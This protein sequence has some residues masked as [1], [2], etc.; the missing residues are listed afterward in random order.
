MTR[1]ANYLTFC[2]IVAVLLVSSAYGS[3]DLS[4]SG[5]AWL[6]TE[7]GHEGYWKYCYEVTWSNL[8]HGVSHL[9]FLLTMLEDCPCLCT[10]GYFVFEDTVGTGPGVYGE[11]PCTVLYYGYFE[12]EGDPSIPIYGPLIKFEPYEGGC[13]PS[14][15]GTAYLCYY[16]VAAP[17]Y[18][19]WVDYL[20]IKF[21][22][23]SEYGT[24]TGPLPSC[25]TGVSAIEVSTWGNVKALYR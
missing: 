12:C 8:P 22:G 25:E 10:P 4:A 14:T 9:D 13:E 16:S 21:S 18:G 1:I 17:V 24:L 5:S 20:A 7:P 23:E 6:A 3:P 11:D 2:G 15:E 19:T